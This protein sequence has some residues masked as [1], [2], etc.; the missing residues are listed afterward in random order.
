VIVAL[1]AK[2]S[3]DA[4]RPGHHHDDDG[5]TISQSQFVAEQCGN[6]GSRCTGEVTRLSNDPM[7]NHE[8]KQ[9]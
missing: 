8:S 5:E 6:D 7:P 2:A 3:A 9:E 1:F 4:P